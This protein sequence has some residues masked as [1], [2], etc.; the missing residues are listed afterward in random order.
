MAEGILKH[1]WFHGPRHPSLHVSSMGN[2]GLDNRPPSSLA[3]EVCEE[4]GIDISMHRSRSIVGDEIGSADLILT[5]EL[6]QKE[7]LLLFFPKRSDAI[8]LLGS[9]PGKQKKAGE[10]ADPIGGT[11]HDFRKTFTKISQAVDRII[12]ELEHLV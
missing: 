8:S 1:R 2:H 7:Y 5:M 10:I 11:I 4:N 9:W 6:V 3:L 12:P